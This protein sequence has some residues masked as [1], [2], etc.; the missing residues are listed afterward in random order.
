M[1]RSAP[2]SRITSSLGFFSP[3]TR[4]FVATPAAG[5]VQYTVQ[6]ATAAPAPRAKRSSVTLGMSE[7]IRRGG[8]ARVRD[9]PVASRKGRGPCAEW[10]GSVEARRTAARHHDVVELHRALGYHGRSTMVRAADLVYRLLYGGVLSRLP[11]SIAVPLGQWGLRLLP[12]DLLPVFR[13]ERSTPRRHPRRRAPPQSNH[14]LVDVLRHGYSPA[15]HGPGFRRG[16]GQEHHSP[17]AARTSAAE[18]RSHPDG[19]GSGARQ[20]QRLPQSR[21]RGLSP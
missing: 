12:L 19:R 4:V 2:R 6:P 15:R 16:H 8:A 21:S 13:N 3:P 14:P 17:A 10:P 18:S 7:T 9:S 11:E 5:S 20:L 1:T